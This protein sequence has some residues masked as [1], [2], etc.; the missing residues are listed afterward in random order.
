MFRK[1]TR[2][3]PQ[4]GLPGEEGNWKSVEAAEME[5][6]FHHVT[7]ETKF[8]LNFYNMQ[9]HTELTHLSILDVQ[10]APWI[11]SVLKCYLL[12]W[13]WVSPSSQSTGFLLSSWALALVAKECIWSW[14]ASHAEA[15]SSD[16]R[17]FGNCPSS[18]VKGLPTGTLAPHPDLNRAIFQNHILTPH[19]L[20]GLRARSR[21][22]DQLGFMGMDVGAGARKE[23]E[24][25]QSCPTLWDPR[26]LQPTRL[27]R[28]WDSPGKNTGVGCHFLLQGI[29]PGPGIEPRSPTLQT[30]NLTSEPPGDWSKTRGGTKSSGSPGSMDRFPMKKGCGMCLRASCHHV[31]VHLSVPSAA[32]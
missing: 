6:D 2:K 3:E 24:V 32:T 14:K 27:L 16:N 23:S 8:E 4:L 22:E 9:A 31:Q 5:T 26:G 1:Y 28:P 15:Q 12:T 20:S 18:Y 29:F 13:P 17:K 7:S 11:P 25:D 21:N 30:D 10:W 19:Y